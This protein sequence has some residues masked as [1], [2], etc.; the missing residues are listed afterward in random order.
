MLLFVGDGEVLEDHEK[1][2]EVV[3]AERELKNIT[4]DE[5]QPRLGSLPEIQD[6][7]EDTGQG[8]VDCAPAQRFAKT[9]SVAR[10]MKDAK[11]QHQH[12]ERENIEENPDI[13]QCESPA[14]L[15]I[16]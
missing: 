3:D 14:A 12:A 9:Y 2:E 16:C 10:P 1:D 11:I 15:R 7:R 13:E 5:L 8:H 4:G 6:G